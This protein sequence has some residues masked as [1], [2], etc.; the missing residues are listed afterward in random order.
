MLVT[1]ASSSL[2]VGV[3]RRLLETSD[4]E[5]WCI[6]HS[7]EIP[8]TDPGLHI[9]ELDLE[10]DFTRVLNGLSFDK[11]IHCAAVT[12]S[13]DEDRYWRLNLDATTQLADVVY[14]NGCRD[15]VYISTRCAVEG[16]GAYGESKLAAERELQKLQW[17]SLLIIRPAEIYG[18]NSKEGIDRMLA[19]AHKWRIV[20]AL[21][22]NPNLLF[23]P[24]HVNDFGRIAADLIMMD[25][26]GVT[27]EYLCGPEDLTGIT[28]ARRIGRHCRAVPLPMWWP[29]VSV[30]LKTLQ[31]FRLSEVKPDQL[32]RLVARKTGTAESSKTNS[33]GLRR[34]L[35]Q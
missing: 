35:L 23:S 5:I 1:G 4:A 3:I 11:V 29:L 16:A 18:S 30:S 21:F 2:A 7:T 32:K 8:L 15:F 24:L 17:R 22:G 14:K 13:F 31:T 12:H 19:I 10:S 34:F 20:P 27:I 9:I 28:L 33:A 25:H 26:K 6:R